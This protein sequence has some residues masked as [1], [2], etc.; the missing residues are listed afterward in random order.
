MS[1]IFIQVP[2]GYTA[3]ENSTRSN[4]IFHWK[5]NLPHVP[6]IED[7]ILGL[8]AGAAAAAAAMRA[9]LKRNSSHR[10]GTC[11]EAL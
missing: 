4:A 2:Y 7:D 8:D 3:C 11:S 1:R 10:P 6:E 9:S 5:I